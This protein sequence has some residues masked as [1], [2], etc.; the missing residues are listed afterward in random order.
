[1]KLKGLTLFGVMLT[2]SLSGGAAEHPACSNPFLEKAAVSPDEA[3][4]IA[5]SCSK[6]EIADL[7][8]NRAY[9]QELLEHFRS[10]SRLEAFSE[11]DDVM[12]YEAQRMFIGLA[13]AFAESAWYNG[14]L[15]AIKSLNRQYDHAIEV[16]ELQLR[17]NEVLAKQE[18][19]L[20]K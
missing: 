20:D 11:T 16:G 19:L 13:E 14:S 18:S 3:R 7:L 8:Y 2:F 5:N 4:Q 10:M 9:H 15:D 12:Y 6:E 17:G 1:M